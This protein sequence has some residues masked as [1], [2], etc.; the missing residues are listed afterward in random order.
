M[1][2]GEM[3]V[4]GRCLFELLLVLFSCQKTPGGDDSG[5][6]IF[7]TIMSV[8]VDAFV[9]SATEG[10][11]ATRGGGDVLSVASVT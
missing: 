5:M 2:S 11:E 6:L 10:S 1:T 9:A 3:I 7:C 8:V 4:S